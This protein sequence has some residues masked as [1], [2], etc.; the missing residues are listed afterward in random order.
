MLKR[1]AKELCVYILAGVVIWFCIITISGGESVKL[2]ISEAVD[3]PS[4]RQLRR[5]GGY[6]T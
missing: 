1:L 6:R 2:G 5:T 3:R 4:V